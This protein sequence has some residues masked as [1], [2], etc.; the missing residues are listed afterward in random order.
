MILMTLNLLLKREIVLKRQETK[1]AQLNHP[2][3]KKKQDRS[4]VIEPDLRKGLS[5]KGTSSDVYIKAKKSDPSVKAA[6]VSPVLSV[7]EDLFD[8]KVVSPVKNTKW[9]SPAQRQRKPVVS[10]SEEDSNVVLEHFKAKSGKICI[11][12]M[13]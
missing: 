11:M 4:F 10:E 12:Y 8:Y 1:N 13:V 3:L 6:A 9:R 2:P 7:T 5:S